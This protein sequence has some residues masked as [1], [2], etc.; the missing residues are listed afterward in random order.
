MMRWK[1]LMAWLIIL[2]VASI[3]IISSVTVDPE[4]VGLGY[5]PF[6][7]YEP[8]SLR[9]KGFVEAYT[10][11]ANQTWAYYNSLLVSKP[12]DP[13]L[14]A[15]GIQYEM[16]SYCD[17]YRFTGDRLWINRAVARA[18]YLYKYRDV[19]GDGIPSWGNYNETYGNS[20]YAYQEYGVWDGVLTT[21][22]LETA[23]TIYD[24]PV[25]MANQT[26]REKADKYLELV[27]TIIDRYH[28]CWTN[29][30]ETEGYYWDN[31][32]GDVTGPIVNR[33]SALCITELKLY[34]VLKD[35]KYLTK[36]R[37]MANL[38]KKNL[39]LRDGAYVWTYAVP[40]ST[41]LFTEDI[42]HGAIDLFAILAYEHGLAFNMTDMERFAKT[43]LEF[44]WR[45]FNAKP[46]LATSVDGGVSADYSTVS[47]NWV[48]LTSFDPAIWLFQWTI[49]NNPLLPVSSSGCLMQG[50]SQLPF[51]Y[52]GEEKVTEALLKEAKKIVDNLSPFQQP[53]KSLA[54]G[55]LSE[56]NSYYDSEQNV[57]AFKAAGKAVVMAGNTATPIAIMDLLI[58]FSVILA[59][60]Q[61][62]T[63]KVKR[64]LRLGQ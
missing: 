22:I 48:S 18:D 26:L 24:H 43:Y 52:P 17:M 55:K 38:F 30:T 8:F 63:G 36:P 50:I 61:L 47:R 33:F 4:R 21:A 15:W 10:E 3:T 1:F 59:L 39:Q 6:E 49:F 23:Q 51:Y 56:A 46:S 5:A 7:G 19:N 12:Y 14:F 25:L 62:G 40:P 57:E 37:A 32:E 16:R 35:P 20:V 34:D 41:Y 45:G 64:K 11:F 13:D 53:F 44:V 27:K 54:E 9:G 29:L 42:S 31:P 2:L 58:V 60:V 28:G